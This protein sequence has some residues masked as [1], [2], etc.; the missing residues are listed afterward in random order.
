[1]WDWARLAVF[2]TR[3]LA[4]GARPS[5]DSPLSAQIADVNLPDGKEYRV[6][7]TQRVAKYLIMDECLPMRTPGILPVYFASA[8]IV[9][10][11]PAEPRCYT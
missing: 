1:V 9:M 5:D 2:S 6:S 8:A 7:R 11:V 4:T 3:G 10:A